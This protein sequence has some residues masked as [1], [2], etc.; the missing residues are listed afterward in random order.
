MRINGFDRLS[1]FMIALVVALAV[2]VAVVVVWWASTRPPPA[3]ILVPMEIVDV[4]GG[5]EQ[6]AVDETLQVESPEDPNPNPS[7]E[8]IVPEEVME[9]LDTVIELSDRATQQAQQV[10]V[11]EATTGVP[12]SAT[13]NGRPG[14]GSAPGQGGVSREDRWFIKFADEVS[15]SEYAAQ[16]DFFGIELGALL[17][18]GTLVYVSQLASPNP[19]KV[20][21]R[22]GKGEERLYMTWQGGSR[23][24]ADEKLF[25]KAGV[26]V[27]GAI[28][29]HFYP[30]KTE[31][32]LATLE[33]Q[34]AR[35]KPTE[36]RRTYFVVVR[37]G[38]GYSFVVTR[39]T[40]LR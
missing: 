5:S 1:A 15:I 10:S 38:R 30:K 36:I 27:K 31:E 11:A 7:P 14:L 35:R 25:E 32:L 6:G 21:K 8:E 17:R 22:T 34:Y 12:G 33:Y 20:I 39:Q 26:N 16:L 18:D 4:A 13:G 19:K 37:Q 40:Y 2:S 9:T 29:F 28:M 24:A 3:E 23:K